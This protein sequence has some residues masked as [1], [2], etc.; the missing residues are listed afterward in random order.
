VVPTAELTTSDGGDFF[1]AVAIDGN[2]IAVGG[3]GSYPYGEIYVYVKPS[4]GWRNMTETARLT[5]TTQYY[6]LIGSPL[7][8]SGNTIV[9][10]NFD[11]GPPLVYQRPKSGWQTTSTP[12]AT[13]N[14]SFV[15]SLAL[16]GN[17]VVVG[18]GN[19]A[20]IF[21]E[22]EGGWTGNINP[23]AQLIPSDLPNYFGYSAAIDHRALTIVVAARVCQFCYPDD[24][25]V[26]SRPT[27]GWI[28]MTQTAKLGVPNNFGL[29]AVAINEDGEAI[30]AGS[31]N[32]TVNANQAQGLVYIF[33]KPASGWKTTKKFS[34]RLI[35]TDGAAND[36]FGTSVGVSGSTVIAGAP[37]ATIGLNAYQGAAYVF[38]K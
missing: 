26:F 38:G 18:E 3:D 34:A 14:T 11:Y 25:Y 23:A 27:Q 9:T 5:T 35:A 24:L 37:G 15:A 16:G 28:D 36:A 32:A 10:A 31:P 8:I 17:T 13:L 21:L 19:D 20:L 2:T 12:S 4:T 30:A 1:N 22:P 6:Y 33:A 7:A 29:A